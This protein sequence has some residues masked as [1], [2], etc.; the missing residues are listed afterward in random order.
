MTPK[1]IKSLAVA[2]IV[3]TTGLVTYFSVNSSDVRVDVTA[4]PTELAPCC[5]PQMQSSTTTIEANQSGTIS[6]PQTSDA[7]EAD[8]SCDIEDHQ[9]NHTTTA[10]AGK[11]E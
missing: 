3:V 2:T 9:A 8:C 10:A 6:E 11:S 7:V 1:L 4:D 5:I